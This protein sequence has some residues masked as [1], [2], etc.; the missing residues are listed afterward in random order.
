MI[1]YCFLSFSVLMNAF[2]FDNKGAL[3][4]PPRFEWWELDPPSSPASLLAMSV[5][6]PTAGLSY[7]R[8]QHRY[9][10]AMISRIFSAWCKSMRHHGVPKEEG[11]QSEEACRYYSNP[12]RQQPFLQ[13]PIFCK[14]S[15]GAHKMIPIFTKYSIALQEPWWEKFLDWCPGE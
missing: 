1:N 8:R 4:L 14:I 11:S 12:Q 15:W 5:T 9:H 2:C 6:T 7:C 10:R 3:A 13:T